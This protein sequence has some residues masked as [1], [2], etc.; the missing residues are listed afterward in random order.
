MPSHVQ[1]RMSGSPSTASDAALLT[2]ARDWLRRIPELPLPG[3]GGTLARWRTLAAIA[4]EDVCGVKVMEAHYDALAVLAELGHPVVP[5]PMAPGYVGNADLHAVWAAEPPEIRLAFSPGPD[6]TGRLDGIKAW[7]SGAD[8]VD[9]ALVTAHQGERRVLARVALAE[10]GIA[11]IES[12]WRAMGMG[13][14]WSGC[15]SFRN[16]HAVQVG[17]ADRYLGR[18][19]FWHGGAG[20]AACWFGAAAAIADTL[21]TRPRA[22]K[23]PHAMAHLGAIDMAL[24]ATA[25]LLRETAARIDAEP[26]LPHGDAVMRVRSVAERTCTEVIDRVGRALGPGPLCEDG[27]HARRCTDLT[28]FI[29]QSHAE[30]DW[31]VLGEAAQARGCTW[32]L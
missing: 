20:V 7:C 16:V 23:N 10:P 9:V 24:S 31:A 4:R 19:G 27:A 28:T 11:R 30:R 29:R 21:R 5:G 17:P 26:E 25:S 2:F 14:V 15:L 1:P 18:P 8:L 12:E 6:G 32:T 3:G 22:A 13:R